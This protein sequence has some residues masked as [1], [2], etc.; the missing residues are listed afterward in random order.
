MTKNQELASKI[1]EGVGGISNINDVFHCAT[2]LRFSLKDINVDADALKAIKGVLGTTVAE[3]RLQIIIGPHVDDV[4]KELIQI[5]GLNK[6]ESIK[7]N[8]D[9]E[10]GK[11]PFSLGAAV[12]AIPTAIL[13]T[14]SDS[15][16]PL[17]PLLVAMGMINV[18]AAIIGPTVLKL[19]DADADL[20]K[21]FYYIG[22]AII[23]FLP[24]FVAITA[25]KH[26]DT[27][28][29]ISVTLACIM[30]YPDIITA[31][32]SE[33]GYTVFGITAPAVTYSS[34]IIP[35]ILVIWIQS[36]VEKLL[37]KIVPNSLKMVLVGFMTLVIM[38]PLAFCVLGPLGFRFGALLAQGVSWLYMTAGPIETALI[39]AFG[40]FILAF[41]VGRPIF[42]SCLGVLLATGVEFTY[43]P[44]A[45]GTYN[46]MVMGIALGYA[47]K[48]KG[49]DEKR[50]GWTCFVSCALGGVSEPILF[51]IILPNPKT[52]PAVFIGGAVSGFLAGLLKV[53]YYQFGPTNALAVMGYIGGE[54][55]A[56][57][58]NGCIACAAGFLVALGIMLLTFKTSDEAAKK[59]PA[60]A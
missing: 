15:M 3:G 30:L 56:N 19:V 5:S 41:G 21:N 60:N 34:Q 59:Q 24:V 18:V 26:F 52:F 35:I 54:G 39:G 23:Y 11:G 51:G 33:A 28:V 10:M 43:M 7:E 40:A 32:S 42:F 48:V 27:N 31:L 53:G 45:M 46:F 37:N 44:M 1:L 22:Q 6:Q 8:L 50:L 20:Y 55:S 13:N 36:Y 58:I 9:N 38:M 47:L 2:R 25:S 16:N 49:G 12:K 29:F 14:F 57:L 17:V 4:Y